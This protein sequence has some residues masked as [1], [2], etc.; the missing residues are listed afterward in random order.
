[1]P[2][3]GMAMR[4]E[5]ALGI[6]RRLGELVRL[7]RG[8]RDSTPALAEKLG[9]S[10]PTIARDITALRERGYAIRAVRHT[11]HWAYELVSEPAVAP[12]TGA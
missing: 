4:Y 11:H 5:K 9:V 2:L 8:G 6:E 12:A 7:L 1:L 10:V 3:K